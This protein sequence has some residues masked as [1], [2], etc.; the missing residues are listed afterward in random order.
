M[1]FMTGSGLLRR[2]HRRLVRPRTLHRLRHHDVARK[3]KFA[4]DQVFGKHYSSLAP[5]SLLPSA[6]K[7]LQASRES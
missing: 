6:M 1:T 5:K 7:L 3:P 4:A 2:G